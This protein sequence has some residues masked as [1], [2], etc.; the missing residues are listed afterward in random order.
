MLQL[1]LMDKN[2]LKRAKKSLEFFK[3]SERLIVNKE[4][5]ELYVDKVPTGLNASVFS[6]DIQQQTITLYNPAR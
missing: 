1:Q 2:N 6:F 3:K 4:N 5:E